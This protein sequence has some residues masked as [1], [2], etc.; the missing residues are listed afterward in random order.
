[1]YKTLY[2][3][4]FWRFYEWQAPYKLCTNYIKITCGFFVDLPGELYICHKESR[5]FSLITY[6]KNSYL[7][8]NAQKQKLLRRKMAEYAANAHL[9]KF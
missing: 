8:A 4:V 9:P 1:M 6:G 2:W 3:R 7:C 5:T